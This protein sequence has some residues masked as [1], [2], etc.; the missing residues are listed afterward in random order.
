MGETEAPSKDCY[1]RDVQGNV[2]YVLNCDASCAVRIQ[3]HWTKTYGCR[4]KLQS[5][6]RGCAFAAHRI[7]NL[8]LGAAYDFEQSGRPSCVRGP[9]SDPEFS[10]SRWC[11][12]KRHGRPRQ[13]ELVFGGADLVEVQI[14]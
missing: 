4:R 1:A 7:E 8:G 6:E 2:T 13:R 5:S 11:E 12:R 9:E 14:S 3:V 10:S